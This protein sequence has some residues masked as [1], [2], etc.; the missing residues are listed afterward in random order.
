MFPESAIPE[1][2]LKQHK[3]NME[4]FK[5]TYLSNSKIFKYYNENQDDTNTKHWKKII[6]LMPNKFIDK[7]KIKEIPS[8]KMIFRREEKDPIKMCPAIEELILSRNEEIWKRFEE[9][10][11]NTEQYSYILKKFK[12]TQ[13][14]VKW[15]FKS[16]S[17]TLK[18]LVP[19]DL[20]LTFGKPIEKILKTIFVLPLNMY[21]LIGQIE[22]KLEN[23][24]EKF[25]SS[26]SAN[27]PENQI[28]C[29]FNSD[30]S[31]IFEFKENFGTSEREFL[32]NVFKKWIAV[33]PKR[34]IFKNFPFLTHFSVS[35][36]RMLA[37]CY[38]SFTADLNCFVELNDLETE[39][40][41]DFEKFENIFKNQSFHLIMCFTEL[42]KVNK[43]DFYTLISNYNAQV[44][45]QYVVKI[46]DNKI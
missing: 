28:I 3:R 10:N 19:V 32:A 37:S 45:M 17:E 21:G 41:K 14:S 16:E 33:K 6:S 11:A 7:F 8:S 44:L 29:T 34:I 15:P 36:L 39:K 4:Y 31:I 38:K 30:L 1:D 22:K 42:T 25:V 26:G 2:F 5:E 20:V 12:Y 23:S 35:L 18:N 27:L 46:L 24:V 43:G 40:C 9:N 13:N